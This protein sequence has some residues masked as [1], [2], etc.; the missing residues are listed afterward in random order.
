[1]GEVYSVDGEV[2]ANLDELEDEG[3]LY[4]RVIEKIYL[5]NTKEVIKAYVYVWRLSVEGKE[6]VKEMPW[7]PL[8]A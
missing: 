3:V 6:K 2:L 7:K 1:L 4:N 8:E 5:E